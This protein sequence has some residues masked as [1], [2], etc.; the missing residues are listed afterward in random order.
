MAL[1]MAIFFYSPDQPTGRPFGVSRQKLM[2]FAKLSFDP[3]RAS[4]VSLNDNG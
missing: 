2:R 4:K 1:F 3:Y